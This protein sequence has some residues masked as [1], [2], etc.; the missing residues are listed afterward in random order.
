MKIISWNCSQA[1]R[2]KL[3]LLKK[4]NACHGRHRLRFIQVP[5]AWTNINDSHV[6]WDKTNCTIEFLVDVQPIKVLIGF[7]GNH[8]LKAKRKYSIHIKALQTTHLQID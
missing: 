8:V 6:V 3:P 4:Y 7:I 1:L 5:E 2:K